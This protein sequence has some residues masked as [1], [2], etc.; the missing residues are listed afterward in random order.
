MKSRILGA[1]VLGSLAVGG[2]LVLR[3][4]KVKPASQESS[5]GTPQKEASPLSGAPQTRVSDTVS[6]SSLSPPKNQTVDQESLKSLERPSRIARLFPDSRVLATE[7]RTETRKEA[8][9]LPGDV[10]VEVRTQIL[11]TTFKYRRVRAVEER[12]S[13]V[14]VSQK[15]VVAE[16]LLVTLRS[17]GDLA[18][19]EKRLASLGSRVLGKLSGA[20]YRVSV[21]NPEDPQGVESLKA[22]VADFPE[23]SHPPDFDG[24]RHLL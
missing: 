10:Q 23:L 16:H 3:S 15:F 7:T 6:T 9:G 8:Y 24:I 14:L 13:G 12:V 17:E 22:K 1:A 2:F 4:F 21:P 19:F 18:E 5:V 20:V 11:D